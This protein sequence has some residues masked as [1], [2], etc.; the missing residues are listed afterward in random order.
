[1]KW[2]IWGGM[3]YDEPSS[4]ADRSAVVLGSDGPGAVGDGNADVMNEWVGAAAPALFFCVCVGMHSFIHF[5]IAAQ[6]FVPSHSSLA[7]HP[8]MCAI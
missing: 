8:F 1:M 7:I 3:V 2:H 4:D 5:Y 6:P